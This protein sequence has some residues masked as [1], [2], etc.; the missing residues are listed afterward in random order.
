MPTKATSTLIRETAVSSPSLTGENRDIDNTPNPEG[1][2][3]LHHIAFSVSRS[4]F[5]AT[6]RRLNERGIK[7]TGEMDRGFMYSIYFRDPL[8]QRYELSNYK[9]ASSNGF[10]G[11]KK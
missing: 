7:N 1:I 5:I 3:N 2:G 11:M 4:T 10:C 8:G 6:E 9:F